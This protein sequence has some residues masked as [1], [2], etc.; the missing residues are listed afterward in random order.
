[1]FLQSVQTGPGTHSASIQRVPGAS[2]SVK[3]PGREADDSLPPGALSPLPHM[4]SWRAEGR[5]CLRKELRKEKL[6]ILY[7]SLLA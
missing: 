4:Y 5:I 7:S 3:W 2:P 1:M 6:H